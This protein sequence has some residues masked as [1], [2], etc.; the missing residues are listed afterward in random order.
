MKE[1]PI[2]FSAPMVR[3]ILAGRKTQTRRVV[4]PQPPAG[5]DGSIEQYGL[6]APGDHL[7]VR[8]AFANIAIAGYPPTWFYR[9]DGEEL[10]PYDGRCVDNRWRP[11]IHMPR[12]AA[13]ILLELTAVH[14]EPLQEISDAD[15]NA[16]GFETPATLYADEPLSEQWPNLRFAKFWDSLNAER[17]YGWDANPWVWVLTFKVSEK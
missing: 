4:R 12:E 2:I 8:E 17:G 13:R 1:H 11:S 7:W 5:F 10:P 14:I 9:A 15:A 6:Y 16:E 3:A